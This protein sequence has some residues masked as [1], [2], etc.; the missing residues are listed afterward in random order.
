[1]KFL[2]QIGRAILTGATLVARF[3]GL[4]PS[5]ISSS[6][7][8]LAHI[9]DDVSK[10]ANIIVNVEA[11]GQAL[12]V[13]GSDKLKVAAPLVSQVILKSSILANHS[14][15]NESLFTA[16]CTKIADGFADVLNSLKV[17]G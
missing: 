8:V 3:E 5:S 14:I 7:P 1:M 13:P 17:K 2:T 12:N 6:V 10:I 16:G 9:E 4:I 15:D 11:I